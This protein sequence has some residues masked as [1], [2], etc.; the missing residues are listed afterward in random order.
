MKRKLI[1]LHCI[2]TNK[3][4]YS[5][6]ID[7][8]IDHTSEEFEE[9]YIG[10]MIELFNITPE[11]MRTLYHDITTKYIHDHTNSEV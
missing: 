6:D 5:M 8:N 2:T 11:K 7:I 3:L 9:I 4:K 1:N 10:E